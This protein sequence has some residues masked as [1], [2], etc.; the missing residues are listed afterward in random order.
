[1][2]ETMNLSSFA[3]ILSFTILNRAVVAQQS[4]ACGDDTVFDAITNSCFCSQDLIEDPNVIDVAGIFDTTTYD[5]GPTIF[6]VTVQL[7]NKRK[8]KALASWS[9]LPRTLDA[10]RQQQLAPIGKFEPRNTTGL[11]TA[12]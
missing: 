7:I 11:P 10:M 12:L 1:M 5:W 2:I 4:A 9:T 6:G 3:V 8:I